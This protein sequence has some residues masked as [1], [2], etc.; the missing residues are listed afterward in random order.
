MSRAFLFPPPPRLRDHG[1]A[2]NIRL[3]LLGVA[4]AGQALFAQTDAKVL[5]ERMQ[6][7]QYMIETFPES[8][9]RLAEEPNLPPAIYEILAR[10]YPQETLDALARNP[11]V[12]GELLDGLALGA[13]RQVQLWLV[14]RKDL[15]PAIRRQLVAALTASMPPAN[16]GDLAADPDVPPD[17]LD[18][19]A[20]DLD[21]HVRALAAKSSTTREETLQTLLNDPTAFVAQYARKEFERRNPAG[22]AALGPNLKPIR[23]LTAPEDPFGYLR[24]AIDQRNLAEAARFLEYFERVGQ[25]AL[26][27]DAG[28]TFVIRGQNREMMDLFLAHGLGRYPVVLAKLMGASSADP[29]WLA[30]FKAQGV[31]QAGLHGVAYRASNGNPAG[32][33]ALASC[34]LDPNEPDQD[35][36]P[37]LLLQVMNDDREAVAA[38]LE[39]GARIDL[40][41]SQ[42]RTPVEEAFRRRNMPVLR[43]MHPTE[44][45]QA[46]IAEFV[47]SFPPAP[48]DSP[49]PGLWHVE[50]SPGSPVVSFE[51]EAWGNLIGLPGQPLVWRETA[52]NEI[53]GFQ[54][55]VKGGIV[56]PAAFHAIYSPSTAIAAY[57]PA[58]GKPVQIRRFPPKPKVP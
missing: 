48:S 16:M 10:K 22:F 2:A 28:A 9:E 43:L 53:D 58:G 37:P 6:R 34:G 14:Q 12:P 5:L 27:L 47:R 33:R 29:Q 45:Y 24:N 41:G 21:P 49:W 55:D 39:A 44:P 30:Y 15:S 26:Q 46:R 38:L 8:R 11:A 25:L 23:Q 31:P 19:C 17:Y 7:Y 35:K 54:L 51:R 52:A 13:P 18:R 4:L 50:G 1:V 56:Q 20:T 3:L 32:I 42:G 57:T 36:F 40:R